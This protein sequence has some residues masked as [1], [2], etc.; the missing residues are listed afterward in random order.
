MTDNVLIDD[1]LAT[2]L[3]ESLIT[4]AA[5]NA[6]RSTTA[7]DDNTVRSAADNVAAD[8]AAEDEIDLEDANNLYE[9][10]Y[11]M[12]KKFAEEMAKKQLIDHSNDFYDPVYYDPVFFDDPSEESTKG[13]MFPAWAESNFLVGERNH[14]HDR[15]PR[16]DDAL[17][18]LARSTRLEIDLLRQDISE[19]SED[20]VDSSSTIKM[21]RHEMNLLNDNIN[22]MREEFKNI[23]AMLAALTIQ[24]AK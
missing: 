15:N 24:H 12:N 6:V 16:S 13:K 5:G 9:Q 8:N 21:L 20:T 17:L 14:D 1:N 11:E 10:E 2:A 22:A 19:M 7:A 18:V 23:T 3:V 4:A